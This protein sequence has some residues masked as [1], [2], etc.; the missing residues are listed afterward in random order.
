MLVAHLLRPAQGGILAHCRALLAD[1]ADH[2]L[3]A[4]PSALIAL[5]GVT[6]RAPFPLTERGDALSQ[7]RAGIAAGRWARRAGADLLHGHGLARSPLFAIASFTA[8]LPLVVTLHNL[9]PVRLPRISR[10]FVRRALGRA[11]RIIAVSDAVAASA[12]GL[13]SSITVVP[14]GID[15]ARFRT[16]TPLPIN[17]PGGLVVSVAR[18]SPEKGIDTLI[19]AVAPLPHVRVLIAG[20]G[21]ERA[22][23]DARIAALGIG[24]RVDLLG[25]WDDVPSL[26]MAAA[27]YVQPSREEGQGI[28]ALEAMAAGRAVIATRVG[29]LPEVVA[30]NVTG[31]LV[32]PDDPTALG[33]AIQALLADPCARRALGDAGARRV[34]ERFTADAMRTATRAL[35]EQ[36]LA[37]R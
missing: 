16:A 12:A 11:A 36:V 26:L 15:S 23:L 10:F 6:S 22:A 14:N 32:P 8:G 37:G 24:E 33:A 30:E 7:L 18:L 19:E 9:A 4:P 3:A 28:A 13:H 27:L 25:A 5:S 21:P 31:W 1:G 2:L 20:E 29:G 34:E 17:A 35:Y